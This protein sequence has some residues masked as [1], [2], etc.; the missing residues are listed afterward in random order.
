MTF[1]RFATVAACC[2]S[3]VGGWFALPWLRGDV[4][5]V[6]IASGENG[7]WF[8]QLVD[9]SEHH[10]TGRFEE[11]QLKP[12]GSIGRTSAPVTG[13]VGSGNIVLTLRTLAPLLT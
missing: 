1:S 11:V 7:A 5:G 2:A 3:L 13:Q 4:S 12:D 6:Y 10:V 8:L 9:S